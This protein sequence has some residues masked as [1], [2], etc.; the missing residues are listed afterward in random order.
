MESSETFQ[1]LIMCVICA[2]F[3]LGLLCFA[4]VHIDLAFKNQTTLESFKV[5][6]RDNPYDLGRRA[7]WE[8]VF[9]T[10]PWYWFVPV[11]TSIGNGMDYPRRDIP[12]KEARPEIEIIEF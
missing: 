10:N 5:K 12:R 4:G 3:G 8:Q 6:S 2:I 1:V 9:G 7:N 11:Y